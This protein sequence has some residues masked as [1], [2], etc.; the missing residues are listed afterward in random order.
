M[1][2]VLTMS[3]RLE[4]QDDPMFMAICRLGMDVIGPCTPPSSKGHRYIL[5]ATDY[6]SKWAEAIALRDVKRDTVADFIRTHIIYRFGVPES[7]IADSAKYFKEGA[8]YK[9]C[10]KYNIKYNHSSR[11]HAPANGL[12]EAFNKTLCKILKKMVDKN[13]RSWNKRLFEAFWAYRTTFRTSTRP[14]HM[15]VQKQGSFTG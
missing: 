8:L 6:F 4:G 11:Y 1:E 14:P 7:I 2:E 10:A 9:L 15:R 5:V 12:A 3:K 13:K